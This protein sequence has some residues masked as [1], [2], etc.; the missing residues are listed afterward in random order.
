MLKKQLFASFFK[1]VPQDPNITQRG[2][3]MKSIDRQELSITE[4]CE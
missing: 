3:L 1:H 4:T 2:C